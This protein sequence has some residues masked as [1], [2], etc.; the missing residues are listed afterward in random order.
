MSLVIRKKGVKNFFHYFT[1]DGTEFVYSAS[2]LVIIFENTKAK[3]RS[4]TGRPIA[5]KDGYLVNEITV[6]DDSTGGGAETFANFITLQSRLIALGYP[7]YY[8]DGEIVLGELI[9]QDANNILVLGADGKL[10]VPASGIG[11]AVDSVNGFT[12]VVVLDTDYISDTAT[13]RYTNDTDITRLLNTSG[14]NTGDQFVPTDHS[15]LNLNDGTNP[16][17]TTKSDVGLGDVNNTSDINKPISSATQLALSEKAEYADLNSNEQKYFDNSFFNEKPNNLLS[18]QKDNDVLNRL[19]IWNN[20]ENYSAANSVIASAGMTINESNVLNYNGIKLV[21][22]K[23]NQYFSSINLRQ[24]I[25]TIGKR[26][27]VS[28]YAT[29]PKGETRIWHN[30]Q[31]TGSSGH[32][33][34]MID[35]N[36]RR[37]FFIGQATSG[38][39]L[40]T[41]T[42]PTQE[43]GTGTGSFPYICVSKSTTI[44]TDLYFG[45]IQIEEVPDTYV[46]GIVWIGDSTIQRDAGTTDFV[47]STDIPKYVGS[48]LNVNCFN[49]AIGGE[50]LDQMDSRWASSITPLAVNCKY[51]VIQGGVNDVSQNRTLAQM[52]ASVN[53]MSAKAI[54]DGLIPIFLTCTINEIWS[55]AQLELRADFNEWILGTFDYVID[56]TKIVE[57]DNKLI[58]GFPESAYNNDGVHYGFELRKAVAKFISEKSFFEFIT[59]SDYQFTTGSF[60][61]FDMLA[62]SYTANE[63]NSVDDVS[64]TFVS[65][66]TN[67]NNQTVFYRLKNKLLTV[68]TFFQSTTTGNNLL[69]GLL[70]VG[71]RPTNIRTCLLFNNNGVDTEVCSV[72]TNGEIRANMVSG[73]SYF[74]DFIIEIDS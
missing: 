29:S 58:S 22:A 27:M 57:R 48:I 73:D 11:G 13:N 38:N 16:H 54:T 65:N 43:I 34:H 10:Y 45:G 32:G 17:G 36:V 74:L 31:N 37:I 52:Q 4:L 15:Q 1:I 2:D 72:S 21:K 12:G 63:Y 62:N 60:A 35:E 51:V 30:I 25:F 6:F 20:S 67:T 56:I 14:T 39:N 66:G 69:I 71:T 47:P 68:R 28:F 5:L 41:I 70:P 55:I 64:S 3:L 49:R 33:A 61:G 50:R 7:A 19:N 24:S 9:S 42:V 46:D 23:G 8:Q 40:D 26:Y 59:P 53:S 18:I 44:F